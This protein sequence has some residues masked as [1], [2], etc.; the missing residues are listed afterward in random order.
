M[1]GEVKDKGDKGDKEAEGAEEQRSR[2]ENQF[3][4][5]PARILELSS[6]REAKHLGDSSLH[7]VAY[8]S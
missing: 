7:C 3:N 6:T 5:P 4:R 2:G 1:R 8:P